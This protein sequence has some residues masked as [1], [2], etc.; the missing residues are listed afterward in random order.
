MIV[1][2]QTTETK[3]RQES[4]FASMLTLK[5]IKNKMQCL[6]PIKRYDLKFDCAFLIM[7][8]SQKLVA[9]CSRSVILS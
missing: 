9:C 1:C 5:E 6:S 7:P 4:G 3:T 8:F 2:N